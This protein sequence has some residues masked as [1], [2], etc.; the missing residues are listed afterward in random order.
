MTLIRRK[1]PTLR[2]AVI[3]FRLVGRLTLQNSSFERSRR[4][5]DGEN[6]RFSN[7]Q[8]ERKLW[9]VKVSGFDN[10][11]QSLDADETDSADATGSYCLHEEMEK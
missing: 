5:L 2:V 9:P 4:A 8:I 10:A 1:F 7:E 6:R 3:I 11:F